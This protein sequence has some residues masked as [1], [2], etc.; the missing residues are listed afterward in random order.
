[1]TNVPDIE[2]LSDVIPSLAPRFRGAADAED[3]ALLGISPRTPY[4]QSE[5]IMIR[6]R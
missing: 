6:L 5:N 1:V 2:V 3:V 4:E